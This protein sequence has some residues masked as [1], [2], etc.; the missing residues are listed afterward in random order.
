MWKKLWTGRG[1]KVFS[2]AY[3]LKNVQSVQISAGKTGAAQSSVLSNMGGLT[4]GKA[5]ARISV[6]ELVNLVKAY[7]KEFPYAPFSKIFKASGN[8]KE[9]YDSMESFHGTEVL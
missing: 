5:P 4:A 7:G 8:R 2:R 3:T 6:A 1:R 9:D